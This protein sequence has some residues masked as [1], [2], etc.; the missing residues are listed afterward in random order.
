MSDPT[1]S[2]EKGPIAWMA[3]NAVASNLLMIILM[4]GGLIF[5]SQTTQE[6]FP[7]FEADTVTVSVAYPGASPEEVERGII[8]SIE[9]AVRSVEG[10]DEVTSVAREGAGIVTIDLLT[11][12][13]R[14]QIYQDIKSEIDRIT[15]FPEESE[16]PQVSL[17]NREM[18]EIRFALYGDLS[19]HDLRELGESV[20]TTLLND[21]SITRVELNNV[22]SLEIWVSVSADNLRK[23]NLTIPQIAS[24]IRTSAVELPSGGL[25]TTAGELLVRVSDRR[26]WAEEFAQIPVITTADGVVVRL[27]E[28]AEVDDTFAD[29]DNSTLVDGKPAIEI[30]VYRIGTQTPIGIATATRKIM[31]KTMAQLPPGV[32]MMELRC[33]A[34]MFKQRAVLLLKNGGYGL[35]L[36]ILLLGLFL[37]TRL[38]WWVM[39]GI[40]IS[41]L[42]SFLLLPQIGITINMISMFAFI[43]ALGIVVD[44]AI[45]VGENIYEHEQRGEPRLRAAILGAREVALPVT[46][47]ILT[48]VVTFVPLM[49]IQGPMGK[50]FKV[51]PIVVIS[52]FIISLFES[53]FVLPSHLG[54]HT[55]GF[56]KL[57]DRVRV[58]SWILGLV[59]IGLIGTD[60]R[61]NTEL[62]DW[63]LFGLSIRMGRGSLIGL[64]LL[65][66]MLAALLHPVGTW[67]L[68]KI[69][70]VQQGFARKFRHWV[71]CVYGPFVERVIRM[72]YMT[73]SIF[74]A[75]LVIA[76]GII[77]GKHLPMIFMEG[78][79][80]DYSVVTAVLPYG[81]DVEKTKAVE[82]K[83]IESAMRVAESH[84]GTNLVTHV[85]SKIGG[86]FDGV[87]GGHVV[88]VY[89]YLTDIKIRPISTQAFTE[90]WRKTLGSIP[91]IKTIQFESDRGGP[92]GGRGLSVQLYH[93]NS[94]TLEQAG[95]ELAEMLSEYTVVKDVSD[96]YT[97]GKV[98]FDIELLPEGQALGLTSSDIASQLRGAFYG[99]EALR[100]QRG[101][102][103][104]KVLVRLPEEEQNTEYDFQ[105]LLI[106]TPAGTDVPLSEIA[107]VSRGRAYTSINRKNGNRAQTVSANIVPRRETAY[108]IE[109][110]NTKLIPQLKAKYPGLSHGYEG[111][112]AD[113]REMMHS[114]MIGFPLALFVIY[115]ML[116]IPFK[117]YSQPLIVMLSI[118]FGIVGAIIGHLTLGYTL[119]MMS[120]MGIV[121]LSGVVV[122]D[123]LVL[124]E[125]ANRLRDQGLDS[126]DA[127]T[128]S[129][130]RRFRPILLTTLTT[131]FGLMPMIFETSRQARF[132][133]PM[134]ISLGFGIL[135]STFIT[136]VLVPSL[137]M[138]IDDFHRRF[139]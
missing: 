92:G 105:R 116:A 138:V 132:L 39:L 102:N 119:S 126:H 79:D 29:S 28:I 65:T 59:A 131:F 58:K 120:M 139:D 7:D 20:R 19:E 130:T 17:V 68:G 111:R 118:P 27:G 3:R 70:M 64:I 122:N 78:V 31:K 87:S 125:Y 25:K 107:T 37:E 47:S 18:S 15:T 57:L 23:Y 75:I 80:A 11:G 49:M 22:R 134:A 133:I 135:F 93:A 41:F 69:H 124:I 91:G 115:A 45:V 81:S 101:R 73:V 34:D 62:F 10:V 104:I 60:F 13:N 110:V 97:P 44:D 33:S 56:Y 2:N 129:A 12:V 1:I 26:D 121:A 48:N 95:S 128:Q 100:Q 113:Q 99:S 36:V 103:E 52:T 42:G 71:D 86:S 16:Q 109:E 32:E 6:F 136:L 123:S 82:E 51:M 112:Q 85:S 30:E 83:L 63:N 114:L 117:S 137:Y 74:I 43:L 89:A 76:V 54:H 98:Q 84:G 5:A 72:R 38:A 21:P 77:A 55:T 106:K 88:E 61:P 14:M 67:L 40:P 94:E 108:V 127:V 50:F 8:E 66:L 46:F 24:K 35:L 9:E 96:G 90:Q 4:V 53:L